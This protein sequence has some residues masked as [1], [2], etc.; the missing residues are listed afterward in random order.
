MAQI[1]IDGI[2]SKNPQWSFCLS[3]SFSILCSLFAHVQQREEVEA[4][5]TFPQ[6]E[7]ILFQD[8]TMRFISRVAMNAQMEDEEHSCW[9]EQIATRPNNLRN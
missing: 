1:S 2:I 5:F 3:G 9:I 4:F 7:I 6:A 8:L